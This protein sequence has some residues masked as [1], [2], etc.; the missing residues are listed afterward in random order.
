MKISIKLFLF[1]LLLSLSS[2]LFAQG[3]SKG[4]EAAVTTSTI[5]I[6]DID[7]N[8]LSSIKGDNIMGYEGG[9]FLKFS[10]AMLYVKPKF[11]FHY[12]EG[13]L[14]YTLNTIE[15]NVTFS[16]GKVL[17]PVMIGYKFLPPVLNLEAGPVF[18]YLV[19]ATKNF[20]GNKVDIEKAGLGYRVGL[21]ADFSI[22]NVAISY[23][24]VKN[25]GSS[26]D[27]A[28]YQSPNALVFGVGIKF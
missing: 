21:S 16:A 20:E 24:G 19:F 22:L 26:T 4:I 28:T 10:V 5:K 6:S 27:L 25:N 23:Q 9:I 2:Q 15:Q 8:T 1:A 12:E 17:V 7:N 18:N 14:N 3:L 13:K 11:L